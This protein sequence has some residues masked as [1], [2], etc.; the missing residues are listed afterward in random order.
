[1]SVAAL[2]VLF[3]YIQARTIPFAHCVRTWAG[4]LSHQ[5]THNEANVLGTVHSGLNS[6]GPGI[7]HHLLDEPLPVNARPTVDDWGGQPQADRCANVMVVLLQCA[8]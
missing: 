5:Q 4:R 6:N 2:C 7:A 1:M 3:A 8:A